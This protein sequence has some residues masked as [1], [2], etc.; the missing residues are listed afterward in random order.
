MRRLALILLAVA[1]CLGASGI[2]ACGH[3]EDLSELV[4]GEPFELGELRF[5][6]L[7][8]RFLNP[9]DVEDRGYLTGQ[10]SAPTDKAYLAVFLLVDNEGEEQTQ[11]PAPTDLKVI[12]TTGVEY[13][14]LP[15]ESP[16]AL[17]LGGPIAAGEERPDPDSVA[18]SGPTQGAMVLFLVD[19]AA[20]ENRPL[21]L[22]ID[23]EGEKAIVELDI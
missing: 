3:E 7:F 17:D 23:R 9:D 11:L 21:E 16:F 5:N 15:S 10:P 4:E 14:P 2:A 20:T 13:Q 6:I 22:E 19:R 12:D 18:A 1:A 8:T